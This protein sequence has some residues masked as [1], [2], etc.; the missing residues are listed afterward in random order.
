MIA[1]DYRSQNGVGRRP[2]TVIMVVCLGPGDEP[3]TDNRTVSFRGSLKSVEKW[4]TTGDMRCF[5]QDLTKHYHM[6]IACSCVRSMARLDD[7]S[8]VERHLAC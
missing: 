4:K 3:I 6:C 1:T 7:A 2:T 8:A 5:M